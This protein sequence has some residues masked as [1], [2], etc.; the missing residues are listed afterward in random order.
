MTM[1][2]SITGAADSSLIN[3]LAEVPLPEVY[4]TRPIIRVPRSAQRE[5]T[6]SELMTAATMLAKMRSRA[7]VIDHLRNGCEPAEVDADRALDR[8]VEKLLDL[9]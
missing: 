8:V 1:T 5:Y 3:P 2:Y 9:V 4:Q 6:D 7:D